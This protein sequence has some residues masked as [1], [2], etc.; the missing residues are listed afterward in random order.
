[1]N[2]VDK[3]STS[4]FL[5]ATVTLQKC[6]VLYGGIPYWHILG[7]LNACRQIT[8]WSMKDAVSRQ[9]KAFN[10]KTVGI[11]LINNKY[12]R[13]NW[14]LYLILL[15][16]KN[17]IKHFRQVIG[18]N[19]KRK[20]IWK[21]TIGRTFLVKGLRRVGGVI[22]T[23]VYVRKRQSIIKFDVLSKLIKRTAF[24]LGNT[25]L[26]MS[27]AFNVLSMTNSNNSVWNTK[28]CIDYFW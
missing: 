2:W 18:L 17:K 14:L 28:S 15:L 13:S 21:S 6:I 20:Q 5:H 11:Y 22:W 26:S 25:V 12:Y 24:S 3:N 16:S 23:S 8:S 9:R 7:F 27:S 19:E 10:T 1:M 4:N